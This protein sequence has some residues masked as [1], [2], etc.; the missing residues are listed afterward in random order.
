MFLS[1]LFGDPIYFLRAITIIVISICLHELAHGLAAISQGDNTPIKTGHMTLN[2][3]VHMGW[4]SLIFMIISGFAV[5]QGQ[6][7]QGNDPRLTVEPETIDIKM[8]ET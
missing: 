2:P 6:H 5:W 8:D 3:I 7:S 4:Y 1:T